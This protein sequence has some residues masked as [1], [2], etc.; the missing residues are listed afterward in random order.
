[1]NMRK[2]KRFGILSAA[3]ALVVAAACTNSNE[4]PVPETIE[5]KFEVIWDMESGLSPDTF[6]T[7][8]LTAR[9]PNAEFHITNMSRGYFEDGGTFPDENYEIVDSNAYGDLIMIESTLAPYFFKT[10][11]LE[12]LDNY[13]GSDLSVAEQL[14]P[15]RLDQVRE[16]GDGQIYG[17]PFGRNVYA[18]Y[19]NADLFKELNVPPPTDGMTWDE[20][21]ELAWTIARNP[22]LGQRAA[23]RIPDEHL[24]YSQF[25]LRVL[26]PDTGEP[27]A[28]SPLWEKRKA[29]FDKYLELY[30]YNPLPRGVNSQT[31]FDYFA[32]GKLAMIAGG[33]QG[34]GTNS[35]AAA[36][37]L[38][39]FGQEWGMV[40]FPA[41]AEAPDTGPAPSYYYLGI[42]KNSRHKRE[43]FQ[44]ISYLLSN[45]PQ[46]NN[47]SNGLA[48][49]SNVSEAAGRFGELHPFISGK[50]VQAY[51]G[52][53]KEG[54]LGPDYDWEMQK[55]GS[56]LYGAGGEVLDNIL[57]YRRQ[58]LENVGMK[59]E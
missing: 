7:R 35:L 22:L 33:L 25:H 54:S 3:A 1:M 31:G 47:S 30:D 29:F 13:I 55:W 41:F 6:A 10:G 44:M 58:M 51:F 48:S 39:P 27:D 17:V 57:G 11:Y 19:Y 12:P 32:D 16:Q 15:E 42:P 28:D 5:G 43:A 2:M 37:M 24:V 36:G 9:F 45:E 14:K 59:N 53:P 46:M 26:N 21:F 4:K 18:L 49:V 8:S 38:P 50:R 52:Y 34:N 23:L 20:V 56:N 40:G